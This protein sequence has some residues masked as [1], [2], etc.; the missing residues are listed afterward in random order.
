MC[1]PV[2]VLAAPASVPVHLLG[3]LGVASSFLCV[4]PFISM[5]SH[6]YCFF[7]DNRQC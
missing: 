5:G 6:C 3:D 7:T 2:G 1:I 4:L